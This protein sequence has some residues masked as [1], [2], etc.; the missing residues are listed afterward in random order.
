MDAQGELGLQCCGCTVTVPV[1][2]GRVRVRTH[3][4][5]RS[6]VRPRSYCNARALFRLVFQYT[7]ASDLV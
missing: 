2:D 1:P 3:E 7:A 6:W 5:G 4:R